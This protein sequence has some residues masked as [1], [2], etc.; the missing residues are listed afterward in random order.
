MLLKFLSYLLSYLT[1]NTYKLILGILGII[2]LIF[3]LFLPNKL[4]PLPIHWLIYI[5]L[6]IFIPLLF[7]FPF[8]LFKEKEFMQMEIEKVKNS[9]EIKL[10]DLSE[11]FKILSRDYPIGILSSIQNNILSDIKNIKLLINVGIKDEQIPIAEIRFPNS[12]LQFILPIGNNKNIFKDMLF[13]M[14]SIDNKVENHIGAISIYNIQEK[15]SSGKIYEVNNETTLNSFVQT[16][17]STGNPII[18]PNIIAKPRISKTLRKFTRENILLF[19]EYIEEIF[20]KN[21]K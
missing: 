6:A 18:K 14:Y 1:R 4:L 8:K 10:K 15:I 5:I 13:D 7:Y 12:Q 20:R 3:E 19:E 16:I 2:A 21:K 9:I 17:N 11:A